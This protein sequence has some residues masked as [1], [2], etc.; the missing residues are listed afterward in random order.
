MPICGPV[1]FFRIC[2][3]S[4]PTC[5]KH[6]GYKGVPEGSFPRVRAWSGRQLRGASQV[7][8]NKIVRDTGARINQMTGQKA[9]R[10]P[11]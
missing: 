2:E 3:Y 1:T 8:N 6:T 4:G 10:M 9:C 7:K 11:K 5:G